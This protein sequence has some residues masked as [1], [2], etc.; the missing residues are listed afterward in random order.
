[1]TRKLAVQLKLFF[2]GQVILKL[3]IWNPSF[4]SPRTKNQ[5]NHIAIM[6]LLILMAQR[7]A[8]CTSHG[9][10]MLIEPNLL[11]FQVVVPGYRRWGVIRR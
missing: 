10:H 1:M 4:P 2:V 6:E 5:R 11:G 9:K 3:L 8:Y 7:Y